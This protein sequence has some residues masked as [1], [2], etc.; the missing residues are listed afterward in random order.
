MRVAWWARACSAVFCLA[1]LV[2]ANVAAAQPGAE[3]APR[4][5]SA[6]LEAYGA[7][8][9]L[10]LVELSPSGQRIAFINVSGE[11][12][13]LVLVD[14][15]TREQLG[16]I[17]VG[18]AKVRDLQWIGENRV[19]VTTTETASARYLGVD[20]T[21]MTVGQIYDPA[22]GRTV[23]LLSNT[24]GLFPALLSNVTIVGDEG[25]RELLVRAYSI[26]RPEHID[27]YRVNPDTGR[28]RVSEMMFP[29]TEDFVFDLVSNRT[30][31][32]SEYD[33][34][35]GEWTLH[36]RHGDGRFREV[37]RTTAPID[38]PTLMGMGVNGDS[39]VVAADR[40]DLD[41]PGQ[42]GAQFFDVDLETGSWRPVRFDFLPQSLLFHPV[43][44]RLVGAGR[45]EGERQIY[46]FSDTDAGR[47]WAQ[48][49]A[50]LPDAP[51][52]IVSWS[53]DFK[54]AILFTSGSGDS[55]TYYLLDLEAGEVNGIGSAYPD[56]TADRVAPSPTRRRTAWRFPAI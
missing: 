48:A 44:G 32:R 21:E 42:E 55:G 35:T 27:L 1:L 11:Q 10:D 6:P 31:A 43:T 4:V 51:P 41:Q 9:S 24:R 16:N 19:L 5:E 17:S 15:V 7:L 2:E 22:S 26:E 46:A 54:H 3:P 47:L 28:A 34:R 29:E 37:W 39:V 40:P 25:A 8:P 45:I 23:P 49:E 14:M 38:R 50:A 53:G 13:R 18:S 20:D 33:S 36:L 52:G 56:I 12:R 30:A